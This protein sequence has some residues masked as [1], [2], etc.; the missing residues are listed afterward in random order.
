MTRDDNIWH[1]HVQPNRRCMKLRCWRN[2]RLSGTRDAHVTPFCWLWPKGRAFRASRVYRDRQVR[3]S[4][5]FGKCWNRETNWK[6]HVNI[7][8]HD[9]LYILYHLETALNLAKFHKHGLNIRQVHES[10]RQS[11]LHEPGRPLGGRNLHGFPAVFGVSA[12]RLKGYQGPTKFLNRHIS[13]RGFWE[14]LSEFILPPWLDG[15]FPRFSKWCLLV[16]KLRAL[17][18]ITRHVH[19]AKWGKL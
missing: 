8:Y 16:A 18:V 15:I 5:Q 9:V 6:G 14:V 13:T 17:E 19:W 3:V 2:T 4:F 1:W 11:R 12:T 10:I 7:L